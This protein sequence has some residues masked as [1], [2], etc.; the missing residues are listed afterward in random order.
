VTNTTS[1]V[2][3]LF[4]NLDKGTN[5]TLTLIGG[6]NVTSFSTSLGS[7]TLYAFVNETSTNI[8]NSTSVVFNVNTSIRFQVIAT[9]FDGASTNLAALNETQLQSISNLVIENISS[10]RISFIDTINLTADNI[11][12]DPINLD[13]YINISSFIFINATIFTNL[14]GKRATLAFYN[15][16]ASFTNPR[17][18]R[19]GAVCSTTICTVNWTVG[20]TV[21]VNVTNF[22][23]YELEETPVTTTTSATTADEGVTQSIPRRGNKAKEEE[24]GLSEEPDQEIPEIPQQETPFSEK[25]AE[26]TPKLVLNKPVIIILTALV[27]LLI[28]LEYI[29]YRFD[30]KRKNK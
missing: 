19:N 15:A 2:D 5:T 21:F 10:G 23:R 11:T 8:V 6:A 17:V 4:Y 7:H 25:F 9:K 12:D 20:Q 24:D 22:S 29:Q 3:R 16:T 18:L 13:K 14:V 28:L 27:V 30:R 1:A 26:L